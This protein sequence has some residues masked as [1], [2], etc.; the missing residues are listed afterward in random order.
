MHG[1]ARDRIT[2]VPSA[3]TTIRSLGE[4]GVSTYRRIEPPASRHCATG[5][6][7]LPVRW[8]HCRTHRSPVEL[9]HVVAGDLARVA[10]LIVE[11]RT[12]A[13]VRPHD[14]A[15]GERLL[16]VRIGHRTDV[17]DLLGIDRDRSRMSLDLHVG[18]SEQGVVLFEGNREQHPSVPALEDVGAGMIEHLPDDDVASFHE[19]HAVARIGAGIQIERLAHPRPGRV[20]DTSRRNDEA[21]TRGA[22]D[23]GRLPA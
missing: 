20:D 14:V 15:G 2:R 16:E 5:S 19:S 22:V 13:G 7:C 6:R 21:R 10:R 9:K 1:L 8:P 23:Q 18:G 12:N 4:A 3:R 11:Q 17:I